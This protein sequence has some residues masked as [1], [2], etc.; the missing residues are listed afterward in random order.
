MI[1]DWPGDLCPVSD[2]ARQEFSPPAIS[3]LNWLLH[4]PDFAPGTDGPQTVDEAND[5]FVAS[6]T[7][8]MNAA[9]DRAKMQY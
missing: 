3:E 8:M 9:P 2:D 7:E 5:E 1:E 6:V 4:D